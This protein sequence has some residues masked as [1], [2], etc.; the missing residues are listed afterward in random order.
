MFLIRVYHVTE[1]KNVIQD[2]KF[3]KLRNFQNAN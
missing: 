3:Y 2:I 1:Y